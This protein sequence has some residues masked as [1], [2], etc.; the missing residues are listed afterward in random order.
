MVKKEKIPH[1]KVSIPVSWTREGERKLGK[2]EQKRNLGAAA[3]FKC[4]QCSVVTDMPRFANAISL[5]LS[6]RI[7]QNPFDG[8][9][10][11]ASARFKSVILYPYCKDS[12]F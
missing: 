7:V 5:S 8:N 1:E 4:T 11:L 12:K 6:A 10:I 3:F 9:V 2:K